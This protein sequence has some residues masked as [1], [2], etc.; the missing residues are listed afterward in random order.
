VLVTVVLLLVIVREQIHDLLRV[1]LTI[2]VTSN[3]ECWMRKMVNEMVYIVFTLILQTI[4]DAEITDLFRCELMSVISLGVM[5]LR[6]ALWKGDTIF[7]LVCWRCLSGFGR[8]R[9]RV[10]FVLTFDN[11]VNRFMAKSSSR[12]C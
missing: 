10:S 6:I 11:W 5:R 4:L 8:N 7:A 1:V 12:F 2:N 3:F 9:N